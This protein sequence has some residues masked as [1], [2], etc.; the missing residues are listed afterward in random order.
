MA[1]ERLFSTCQISEGQLNLNNPQM[2]KRICNAGNVAVGKRPQH[3]ND[4][5][6]LANVRQKR[7]A[8]TFAVAGTLDQTAD[9]GELDRRRHDSAAVAHLRQLVETRIGH[10]GNTNVGVG[11][12]K[13]IRRSVRAP[14]RECVV[15]RALP[16]VG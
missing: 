1:V 8:K 15:Q 11:C 16:R 3:E 6:N 7:I 13:C 4:G 14:S 5:I 2:L 10:L 12:G 9:I